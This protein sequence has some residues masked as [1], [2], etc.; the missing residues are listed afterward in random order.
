VVALDQENAAD[1]ESAFA[2]SECI[3]LGV[4]GGSALEIQLRGGEELQI[5]LDEIRDAFTMPW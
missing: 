3:R 5:S 2:P 4:S 1:F